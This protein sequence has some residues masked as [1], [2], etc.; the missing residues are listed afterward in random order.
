MTTKFSPPPPS[1]SLVHPQLYRSAT[2]PTVSFDFLTSLRLTT[3]LALGDDLPSKALVSWCE[4]EGVR[5]VRPPSM[6]EALEHVLERRNQPCLIM[7][8]SGIYETG[9]LV[10]CLR[11]LERW[12]LSSILAEY[13]SLAGSR[14]RG[15]NELVIELF[16]TDLIVIPP[17]GR[18]VPWFFDI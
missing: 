6:K 17:P 18:L 12:T 3:V 11:R 2:P 15:A 8:Q 13:A 10:G 5:F 1:F 14:S 16:D 7:D 9:V 4:R